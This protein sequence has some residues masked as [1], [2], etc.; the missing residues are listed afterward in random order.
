M[1]TNFYFRV[2]LMN[3]WLCFCVTEGRGSRESL[4]TS[5]MTERLELGWSTSVSARCRCL[6]CQV[7][8]T[9][10]FTNASHDCPVQQ[11]SLLEQLQLVEL[12]SAP[13]NWI[14]ISTSQIQTLSNLNITK[15]CWKLDDSLLCFSSREFLNS[16]VWRKLL[17]FSSLFI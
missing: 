13:T 8:R 9:F 4:S 7:R 14:K 10:H 2:V 6:E 15:H 3:H 16:G 12:L 5:E 1:R 17:I 11:F